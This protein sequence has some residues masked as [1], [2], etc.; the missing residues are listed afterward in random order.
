MTVH[1]ILSG[2]GEYHALQESLRDGAIIELNAVETTEAQPRLFVVSITNPTNDP[3][4]NDLFINVVVKNNAT[5][6]R[7]TLRLSSRT[8]V[9]PP[10]ESATFDVDPRL[11][12]DWEILEANDVDSELVKLVQTLTE[13]TNQNFDLVAELIRRLDA[14]Q[15]RTSEE[16][17]EKP[18]QPVGPTPPNQPARSNRIWLIAKLAA[19]LFALYFI[20][21]RALN[22]FRAV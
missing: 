21:S 15:S 14:R 20:G 2:V 10:E 16:P 18:L 11:V 9:L 22:Q 4:P 17:L 8:V 7:V 19:V 13:R 1:R 6:Q 5:D 3:I 12:K